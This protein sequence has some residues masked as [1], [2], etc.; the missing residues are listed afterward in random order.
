V[1]ATNLIVGIQGGVNGPFVY[2][3][4]YRNA[5]VKFY[6]ASGLKSTEPYISDIGK[7]EAAQ[8]AQQQAEA[9]P[10]PEVAI[11]QARAQNAMSEKQ[12]DAQLTQMKAQLDEQSSQAE[13]IRKLEMTEAERRLEIEKQKTREIELAAKEREIALGVAAKER[14]TEVDLAAHERKSTLDSNMTEFKHELSLDEAD[15]KAATMGLPKPDRKRAAK[16]GEPKIEDVV[17]KLAEKISEQG[18]LHKR[19][20]DA[21]QRNLDALAGND[22][23][24][25]E[26][27]RALAI[28]I[29]RLG[30]PKKSRAKRSAD[31]SWQIEH[32]Q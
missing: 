1:E 28:G 20:L 10:P 16:P 27:I 4:H 8:I 19:N 29:E 2:A 15:H 17:T 7:E 9:P 13:H 24:T 30:K 18:E 6:E 31:G 32:I 14:Q 21:Q 12:A 5:Y 11:E 3:H 25:A 22:A 26:M 23:K